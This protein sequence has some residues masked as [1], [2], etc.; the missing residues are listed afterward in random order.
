MHVGAKILYLAGVISILSGCAGQ[1]LEPAGTLGGRIEGRGFTASFPQGSGWYAVKNAPDETV[2]VKAS[3]ETAPQGPAKAVI[4]ATLGVR[5][6]PADGLSGTSDAD[7][8]A[9]VERLLAKRL[10][11]PPA[12]YAGSPLLALEQLDTGPYRLQGAVCARYEAFQIA[13]HSAQFREPQ[14]GFSDHGI[15]C[16]HPNDSETLVQVFFNERY[17]R[18]TPRTASPATWR[19]VKK[20]FESLAFTEVR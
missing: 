3:E 5:N 16:R 19:Q 10:G 11:G 18:E 15:V 13:R 17:V 8:A 9:E 1:S 2:F 14:L 7:F 12:F 6:L 20:A 4:T